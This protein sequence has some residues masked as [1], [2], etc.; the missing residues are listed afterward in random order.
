[1]NVTYN[2]S[3]RSEINGEVYKKVGKQTFVCGATY[4]YT[5][6]LTQ[7]DLSCWTR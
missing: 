1:M 5:C 6:F 3:G 7:H 2:E 4:I